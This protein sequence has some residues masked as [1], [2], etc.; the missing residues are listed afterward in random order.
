MNND[1][2]MTMLFCEFSGIA[3]YACNAPNVV[4]LEAAHPVHG[5][6]DHFKVYFGGSD[7]TIG[8][9]V[10]AVTVSE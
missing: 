2:K 6:R 5:K 9:A 3:P 10:I 1:N 8:S 7:A 4:F